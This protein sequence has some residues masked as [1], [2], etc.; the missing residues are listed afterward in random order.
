MK[1][2]VGSI[3][4]IKNGEG[5]E[6]TVK[7]TGDENGVQ[8]GKKRGP[9]SGWRALREKEKRYGGEGWGLVLRSGMERRIC[10]WGGGER[11]MKMGERCRLEIGRKRGRRW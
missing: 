6:P 4:E 1:K 2:G 3:S 10:N 8:R 11:E 9:G 5:F 7:I